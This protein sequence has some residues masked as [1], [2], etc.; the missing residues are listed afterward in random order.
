MGDHVQVLVDVD[1][2]SADASALADR[3]LDWLV[4]EGI[5]L[6]ERNDGDRWARRDYPP[7]AHW[8]K[9]VDELDDDCNPEY[10]PTI[11]IGRTMFHGYQNDVGDA[12]CPLCARRTDFITED[13]DYI[14]GAKEPFDLAIETWRETGLAT[15]TCG[16][17]DLASDVQAWT[18]SDG[19]MA[20][21][22]LGFEFWNWP[23]FTSRFVDEFAGALGGHRIARV[24]GKL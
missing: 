2:T 14:E 4:R 13:W 3:A 24:W 20:L 7:G 10:G 1:A 21:G 22:Y 9:A 11:E 5:V 8:A 16:Y 6:A 15:V 17:C 18:W 19:S 12:T 23:D